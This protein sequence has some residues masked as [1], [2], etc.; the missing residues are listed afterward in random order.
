M[1]ADGVELFQLFE[2]E[3]PGGQTYLA[4]M[5]GNAAIV[6]IADKA[7]PGTWRVLATDPAAGQR[8]RGSSLRSLARPADDDTLIDDDTMDDSIP[9][10]AEP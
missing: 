9:A 4:G 10:D 3:G 7:R 8:S 6:V 2:R 5:L 1:I